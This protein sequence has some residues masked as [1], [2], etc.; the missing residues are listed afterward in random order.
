MNADTAPW[1]DRS[2]D[3]AR[4]FDGDTSGHELFEHVARLIGT[5]GPSEIRISRSQIAFRRGRTFA[6]VWRPSMYLNT[7]VPIVLSIA[8]P[9]PVESA[10]F[11]EVVHPSSTT[12]MHHLELRVAAQ[13]DDEVHGWLA[14]AWKAAGKAHEARSA[15]GQRAGERR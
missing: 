4:F 5:L 3:I 7:T 8:L 2:D 6:L 13:I 15:S 14:R 9:E 1:L 10:R 11:K 12:W